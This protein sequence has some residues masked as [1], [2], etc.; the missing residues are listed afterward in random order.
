MV[1]SLK[2][3]RK[4]IMGKTNQVTSKDNRTLSDTELSDTELQGIVG[5]AGLQMQLGITGQLTLVDT[6]K[7]QPS[8]SG[9]YW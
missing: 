7:P 3:W 4:I 2:Q 9:N 6:A 8:K 1:R 5:G